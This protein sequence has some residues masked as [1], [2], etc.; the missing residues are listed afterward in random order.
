MCPG[1]KEVN[2]PKP[3]FL[4]AGG[5][6]AVRVS[7]DPLIQAVFRECGVASPVVAYVGTAHGDDRRFFG[8]MSNFLFEAGAAEVNHALMCPEGADLEKAKETLSSADLVYVGGGDVDEGIRVLEERKM[9]GFLQ[10]LYEDGKPFF[11][12]SAGAI[13]LAKKW[14]RWRNPDDDS[15]AELFPCLGIAPVVCDTHAEQDDWEELKMALKLADEGEKGYGIVSGTAI[16]VNPTG[17]VH[18]IGDAAHQFIRRKG[19]AVRL[20]DLQQ[21]F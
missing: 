9:V 8:F 10:R 1:G 16:K 11:G 7:P 19:E 12:V 14:V 21:S 3:V 5:R 15:T 4:L 13:M 18:A 17:E 2:K 6:A 20:P